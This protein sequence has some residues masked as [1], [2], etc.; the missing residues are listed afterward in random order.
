MDNELIS[1]NAIVAKSGE[2]KIRT[3]IGRSTA[4]LMLNV[5]AQPHVE[6]FIRSLGT[7]E[8][9]DVQTLGR[10]W[11]APGKD[12]D[13]KVLVYQMEH[14]LGQLNMNNLFSFRLDRPGYPLVEDSGAGEPAPLHYEDEDRLRPRRPAMRFGPECLNLSFLRLVGISEVG[15]VS[16]CVKGVYQREGIDKLAER[17]EQASTRFYREFLKPYK[18]IVTTSVMAIPG[19]EAY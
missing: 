2:D 15:G 13:K 7:G 9:L 19:G 12:P 11:M 4:G 16:F 8:Q 10:H 18:V 17:I 5:W 3:I 14:D 1:V 6:D